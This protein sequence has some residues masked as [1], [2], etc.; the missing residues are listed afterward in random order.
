M[1][2]NLLARKI[3]GAVLGAIAIATILSLFGYGD[4]G[5]TISD[6]AKEVTLALTSYIPA[7]FVMHRLTKRDNVFLQIAGVTLIGSTLSFLLKLI[8][9]E[10][11]NGIP[12]YFAGAARDH[13]WKPFAELI[14]DAVSFVMLETLVCL[15]FVALGF[16]LYSIWG[17]NH[18]ATER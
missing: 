1:I 5:P 18:M 16:Y 9:L 12:A 7:A 4:T 11:Q 13:L 2:T 8:L 14:F 15:P 17:K 6:Y 3:V 10:G